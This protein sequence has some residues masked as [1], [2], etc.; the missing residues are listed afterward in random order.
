[1]KFKA[2]AVAVLS[3][4]AITCSCGICAADNYNVI[5]AE[6]KAV[7]F[8][9]D[10]PQQTFYKHNAYHVC[11]SI[12]PDSNKLFIGDGESRL[13]FMTLQPYEN[14][15]VSY[16]VKE[17]P[18]FEPNSG[19]FAISATAGAHAQNLGYWLLGV[20]NGQWK[21]LVDY[22]KLAQKGF[23]PNEWNRLYGEFDAMYS[24]FAITS[25]TEYMPPWGQT[26][27][28]LIN[29]PTG[30]W[31]CQ[32][33]DSD[34]DMILKP[35]EV[36]RPAFITSQDQAMLYMDKWLRDHP[37]YNKYMQGAAL[38][39]S[40]HNPNTNDGLENHEI[41]IIEDHPTHIIT[42]ATFII[43]ECADILFYDVVAD[44]YIKAQ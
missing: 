37:K 28:D 34:Q 7:F 21:I 41:K 33:S 42:R 1:M 39:Y 19:L 24:K 44:K 31:I 8:Y 36:Q 16:D 38:S 13:N 18:V 17:I 3:A 11:F 10:K 6:P 2:N 22:N 35:V 23:K 25:T 4:I 29:W 30:K 15:S 14:A 5:N 43:N 9:M 40:R 27:V 32:W 12:T 20:T 26:S